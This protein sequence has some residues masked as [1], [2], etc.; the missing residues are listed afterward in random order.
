[1][2][3]VVVQ[4]SASP[5]LSSKLSKEMGWRLV[6]PE[7]RRFPDGEIYLR[8][9]SGLRGQE[10]VVV[11]S[12]SPPQ[13]EHLVELLLLLDLCRDLGAGRVTAVVPY[14]AYARQDKRFREGEAVSIK[15]VARLL[16]QAD[17]LLLVEPHS[18]ESL[19][20]FRGA[21]EIRV[22]KLLGEHLGGLSLKDPLFLSPDE[23][24]LQ[25]VKEAAEAAG[26]EFDF[27]RKERLSGTKVRIER[28]RP[29]VAG[30]DVVV[31]DDIISTGGTVVEAC[32]LLRGARKILACCVH[33]LFVG[34]AV[35]RMRR[36]GIKE[37][38]S[39]D[40]VESS[41]SRISVVPAI[42]SHL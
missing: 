32:K 22:F 7:M 18:G 20:Y 38:F 13:N 42:S 11:Q 29:E 3:P 21:Q 8:I 5:A 40:T 17:R 34:D 19:S 14:L 33:G 6:R 15:T 39:T 37:I 9:A 10:V 4:G 28:R 12:L 23:G 41:F 36:A 26:A 27:L 31:L 1:M 25:R 2:M 16:E 24:S 35:R 30:R